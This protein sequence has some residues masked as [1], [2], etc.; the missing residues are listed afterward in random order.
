MEGYLGEF[1]VDIS[2]SPYKDY[3]PKDWGVEYISRYGSIDGSHHKDWV[4]DQVARI[5]HG[6][7]VDVKLAKWA[8]GHSEYRIKTAE[9][10]Q[11]Y[12]DW[13]LEMKGELIDGEYE[14]YYEEGIAP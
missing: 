6:T 4:L 13:V 1:D 14:Y 9:P 5:L 12:H 7:K 8:N 10:S 2:A 11:E 3:T